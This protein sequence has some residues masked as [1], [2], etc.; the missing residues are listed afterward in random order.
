MSEPALIVWAKNLSSEKY[1]IVDPY[2]YATVDGIRVRAFNAGVTG[3]SVHV[4]EEPFKC[5]V[6]HA[7]SRDLAARSIVAAVRVL[8]GETDAAERLHRAKI[9]A[10]LRKA[11]ADAQQVAA[12]LAGYGRAPLVGAAVALWGSACIKA[13]LY[14]A[15]AEP[16]PPPKER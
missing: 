9:E 1:G 13:L 4:Y 2:E 14:D 8:R 12:T 6:M 3:W 7:Q 15:S 10:E 16:P 5:E 11:L